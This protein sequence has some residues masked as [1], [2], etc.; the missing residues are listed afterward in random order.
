M[1]LCLD[2]GYNINNPGYCDPGIFPDHFDDDQLT[3]W[4]LDHG[5]DPNSERL[6][7]GGKMGQTPVSVA[8]CR[9]TFDTIQLLIE[10][11][12]PGTFRCG[13]LL[14]YAALRRLPDRLEV[15]E[16]LLRNGAAADVTS[17]RYEN[18]PEAAC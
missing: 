13:H 7:W 3:R 14:W 9:A 4:L 18:R 11:G 8:M 2:H 6:C 15:M 16:Y 5:A 12:G 1:Q 17:L 10:R